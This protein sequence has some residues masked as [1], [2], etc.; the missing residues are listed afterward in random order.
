MALRSLIAWKNIRTICDA[1]EREGITITTYNVGKRVEQER[2]TPNK[3]TL[4][5]NKNFCEY[6]KMRGMEVEFWGKDVVLDGLS[7]NEKLLEV[8]RE[9]KRENEVLRVMVKMYN[10]V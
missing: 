5:N 8:I 10:V 2:L 6:I 3:K 9:L 4:W 7:G 1:L